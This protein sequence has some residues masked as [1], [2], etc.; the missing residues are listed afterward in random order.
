MKSLIIACFILLLST[1][2]SVFA[3]QVNIN[4]ADADTIATEISGIGQS[5][6]KAIVEYRKANGKFQTIDDLT[7]V[8]GIGEKTVEKNRG[9]I[10]L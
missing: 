8:K 1:A 7:K 2:S 3:A 5:R 9:N 10:A 6:A 4:T